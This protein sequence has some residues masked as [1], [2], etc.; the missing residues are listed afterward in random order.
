MKKIFY[1]I[2]ISLFILVIA[3]RP[4]MAQRE[5]LSTNPSFEKDARAAVD[6]LYNL[7]YKASLRI[8]KP[9][10]E[11]YP[12]NPMWTF[13]DGLIIWWHTL[14]DLIDTSHDKKLYYMMGKASYESD[15]VLRKHPQNVDA[16][17]IKALSNGLIA[18]QHANREEWLTSINQARK[19]VSAMEALMDMD[20]N[21]PDIELGEGIEKY[22][23]AYLPEAYP[24][25]KTV[26]WFLPD[27]DKKEG[28]K[29][30]QFAADSG[31]YIAPEATYFLGKIYLNHEHKGPKA[32][33]YFSKLHQSYPQNSYYARILI[34]TYMEMDDYTQAMNQIDHMLDTWDPSDP[35]YDVLREELLAWKG[36]I[37]YKLGSS[38]SAGEYFKESYATGNKLPETDKR[39]FHIMSEYY[40]GK[41]H[42][43]S[44][45]RKLARKYLKRVADSDTDENYAQMAHQI[46]DKMK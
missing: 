25:V 9:W 16:L 2:L 11:K 4:G 40:L 7:N 13:W 17:I 10:R 23:A 41:I 24:V 12:D 1:S 19:A 44:G 8:I 3:T 43:D 29:K 33:T 31:I 22:Y 42:Y 14:P 38:Q 20:L 5:V 36:R 30:L 15:K 27:G 18:R 28:L 46:L 26:S 6:S 35:Y 34:R 32:L 39:P 45:D 37:F 21:L